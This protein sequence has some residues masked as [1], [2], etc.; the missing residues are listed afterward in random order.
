MKPPI[1]NRSTNQII[2]ESDETR[3]RMRSRTRTR[4][5][6]YLP[7]PIYIYLLK[8]K[9]KKPADW[10]RVGIFGFVLMCRR[11][12]QKK[13][14]VFSICVTF[15][16]IISLI[17]SIVCVSLWRLYRSVSLAVCVYVWVS[18]SVLLLIWVQT[19]K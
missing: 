9:V 18:Q 5:L 7:V 3:E 17:D 11:R 13:F 10:N 2:N 16:F 19:A 4:P 12:T 14:V 8:Q 1:H 6:A 15:S